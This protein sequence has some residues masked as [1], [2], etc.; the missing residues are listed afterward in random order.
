M[1]VGGHNLNDYGLVV[2]ITE[3]TLK[4]WQAFYSPVYV[5]QAGDGSSHMFLLFIHQEFSALLV[6]SNHLYQQYVGTTESL[7]LIIDHYMVY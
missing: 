4:P 1:I 7:I 6:E 2:W 5:W 3:V